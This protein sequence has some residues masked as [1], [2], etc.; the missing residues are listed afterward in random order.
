MWILFLF[1]LYSAVLFPEALKS[2]PR[3]HLHALKDI[4]LSCI[5][6]L[7]ESHTSLIFQN[8]FN[9]RIDHSLMKS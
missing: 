4:S 6:Y 7:S 9:V 2:I 5:L 1:T 8:L 3:V